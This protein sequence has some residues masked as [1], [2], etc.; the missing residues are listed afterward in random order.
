MPHIPLQ[1]NNP[2]ELSVKGLII[3]LGIVFG[4]LGTS[5]LYTMQAIL[6]T[7]SKVDAYFVLGALSCIFWTLTLQTT[8][9][10][11]LIALRA[12][13][14]GEGGIFSL[15][16]LLKNR[17]KW[18]Y[19][20][21]IIGACALLGDGVI[22]P[23]ITVTSAMEGLKM[24]DPDIPVLLFVVIILTGIFFAQQFGTSSLGRYFGPIMAVWFSMLLVFGLIHLVGNPAILKA[25]NPYYAYR[26][27]S[28]H[29]HALLLLGAVFLCTT[30]A[31]ALYSD[32]GQCGLQNIRISWGFVKSSL[33]LN[34]FGQGAWVLSHLSSEHSGVNPF[35]AMMP[36]WFIPIGITISTLAAIIA[37]QALITG[38]F[39]IVSEAISLNFFP[40]V[41][42]NY[43]TNIKGQMYIPVI[44][45]TL[46]SCCLFIVFYFQSSGAMQAAYGLSITVAMLMTTM[47]LISYLKTRIK[48][49][50]L[51]LFA[52]LFL[53]IESTFLVANLMKF[54]TGGWLSLLLT[55]FFISIM[56]V[57]YRGAALARQ[58]TKFLPMA[59]YAP[60][61]DALA[62]DKTINRYASQLVY[63]TDSSTSAQIE[64]KVIYSIL[65]N[66]P[67][68]AD[69]YWLLHI[70]RVDE[71]HM[72]EYDYE[73]V[74]KNRL[75][76]VN[77]RQGFK[78][79]PRINRY[80]KQIRQA[81]A[82]QKR[83]DQSS[84]YPS[85]KALGIVSACRY[86]LIEDVQ[87]KDYEFTFV[88]KIIMD[89][90]FVLKRV[91]VNNA[92]SLGLD[93]T[94]VSTE[95][96]PLLTEESVLDV[97]KDVEPLI[98]KIKYIPK[99]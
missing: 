10:Y 96:I 11:V 27:I 61:I 44:N 69:I 80:F 90:F 19:V 77:I 8:V 22:T 50:Q 93:I 59:T 57:W 85:L 52:G 99:G 1:T 84:P 49:Y 92:K 55:L 72:L 13:N 51:L 16:M 5:P 4:D 33:L 94:R 3:T 58:F 88:K 2:T 48:T 7:A 63:I 35:F 82:D 75:I 34:Y 89:Y 25:I 98:L 26:I 62:N 53:L 60:M 79:E 20:I 65:H 87:V 74:I 42:I 73:E 14:R 83:I 23:S 56:Y 30:G 32:V 54:L 95:E 71:P 6:G 91:F 43:P 17:S 67:K 21:A 78:E 97:E 29:P 81:L 68:R 9:K 64:N 40:K 86:I 18:S 76:H 36:H 66:P 70:E 28:E 15:F 12:T 38:S 46:Y 39:S 41:R 45:W 24:Y 47:L 37:S 31:E